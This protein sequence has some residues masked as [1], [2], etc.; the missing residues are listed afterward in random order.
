MM[1]LDVKKLNGLKEY[2][3]EAEFA[4]DPPEDL[5]DIP[6]VSFGGNAV[7]KISYDIFEDGEV[8]ISGEVKYRLKGLC[9]GCLKE[10][11][12]EVT[13]GI[14]ARYTRNGDGEDYAY[15]GNIIDLK[16]LFYDSIVWSM[17]RA[18]SCGEDCKGVE[19]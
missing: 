17:P 2:S 13:G 10:T 8:K 19:Y 3:G 12:T 5:I 14:E 1:I 16:E 7:A 4:F 11:E 15:D 9:S 18:L 6:Y